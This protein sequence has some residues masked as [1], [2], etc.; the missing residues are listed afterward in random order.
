MHGPLFAPPG[1][2]TN[3]LYIPIHTDYIFINRDFDVL[4]RRVNVEYEDDWQS[5]ESLGKANSLDSALQIV[6]YAIE[7]DMEMEY[8]LPYGIKIAE[9]AWFSVFPTA[10]PR[11]LAQ[12][13]YEI[14][15]QQGAFALVRFPDGS[16]KQIFSGGAPFPENFQPKDHVHPDLN[17]GQNLTDPAELDKATQDAA[18][19]LKLFG[20]EVE[21]NIDQVLD[22]VDEFFDGFF[23]DDEDTTAIA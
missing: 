15:Q 17:L 21:D 2:A 14:L 12:G 10:P 3:F 6:N 8:L 11:T 16:V 1:M 19:A 5:D 18:D 20:K 22:E 4:C 7:G 13:E 23:G 9:D